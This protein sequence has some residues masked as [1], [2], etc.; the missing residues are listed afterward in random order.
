MKKLRKSFDSVLCGVCGGIAE[1]L[2]VDPTI[3]RVLWAL[4]VLGAGVGVVAYIVLA[5]LMP[6]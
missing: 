5:I 3:V 4:A 1:Y 2:G 6:D